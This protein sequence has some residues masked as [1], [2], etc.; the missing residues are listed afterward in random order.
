MFFG[1]LTKA[2]VVGPRKALTVKRSEEYG[3]I[4]DSIA[5]KANVRLDV[6][7]TLGEAM[8]I[9]KGKAVGLAAKVSKK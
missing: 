3:F 2:L 5:V 9:Y 4:D 6:K 1:D 7:K 8:A